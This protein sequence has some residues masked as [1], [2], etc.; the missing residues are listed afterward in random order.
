[1]KRLSVLSVSIILLVLFV[2]PY[3]TC[4]QTQ[5]EEWDRAKALYNDGL[6]RYKHS[7]FRG[8]VKQWE[9]ALGIAKRFG[10]KQAIGISIGNLAL[11]YYS[12]SDYRKAISYYEKA[13]AIDEEIGDRNGKGRHLGNLGNAYLDL[14]DYRKAISYYE[15]ALAIAEEI[16]DRQGKGV[17]LIVQI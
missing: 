2:I 9:E 4:A 13:L 11:A 16:G 7:D 14:G 3:V 5:Q 1:M 12:L 8:A 6:E 15:Q 17:E 10:D